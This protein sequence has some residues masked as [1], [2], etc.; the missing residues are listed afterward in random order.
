MYVE[1]G[2]GGVFGGYDGVGGILGGRHGLI[3]ILNMNKE[4]GILSSD[5]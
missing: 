5:Q 3:T 2:W 4:G 1:L